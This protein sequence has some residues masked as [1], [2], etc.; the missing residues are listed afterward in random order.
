MVRLRRALRPWGPAM[1]RPKGLEP[2]RAAAG[3]GLALALCGTLVVLATGGDITHGGGGLFLIAP[4]GATAFLVFGVPN[5]PLAQPWSAVVGNTVSAFVAIAMLKTGLPL[6][7]CA[8][9]AVFGSILA[10]ALL[11][12]M[13]PPGGAVA[14]AAILSAPTTMELGFRF[15]ATP[16]LLD[17][18]LLVVI[19]IPFNRVTGRRYPL[20][21]SASSNVHRTLDP[22]PSRRL[23]L[24]PEDLAKLLDRFN[25]S[26]NIGAEDLGR[27]LA[28]AEEAAAAR[29]FSGL[30]CRDIM[31]RDV[32]TVTPSTRSSAVADLFR[33][34]R[35]RSIPVV[36]ADNKLVGIITQSDLIER[37][38]EDALAQRSSF[39]AGLSHIF[40]AMHRQG[41]VAAALMTTGLPVVAPDTPVGCLV[42]LLADG[43][44][45]VARVVD[46]GRLKGIITRSDLLAVLAQDSSLARP[47]Q[48]R[49]GLRRI[50]RAA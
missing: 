42:G 11:R 7:V 5:S 19:A 8:G 49:A 22:S 31:S 45:E 14:L 24:E 34:H 40:G 29:R 9:L 1:L 20:R 33:K 6:A 23:G 36:E 15:A 3:A 46:E 17:T 13:H 41:S 30:T 50:A 47:V 39:A 10:M 43:G 38:R 32:V 27:L 44:T 28:A 2:L 21:Q 35:F 16:V 48:E 4:L 26:T 25:Q 37:A 18:L 12:A